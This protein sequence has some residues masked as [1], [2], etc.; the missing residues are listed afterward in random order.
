MKIIRQDIW[1]CGECF[2]LFAHKD[3]PKD[4]LVGSGIE[5]SLCDKCQSIDSFTQICQVS[6][7]KRIATCGTPHDPEYLRCCRIHY[8]AIQANG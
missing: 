7:C 5:V 1:E 4:H 2:K 6:G 8:D 3:I